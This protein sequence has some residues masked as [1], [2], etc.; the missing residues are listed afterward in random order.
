MLDL[1]LPVVFAIFIWWFSTGVVILLNRMSQ[2]GVRLGQVLSS[3]LGLAALAGLTHTAWQTTEA[4]AYCAFTCALLVWG[5][6]EL[7]FLTGWITGP[8]KTRL[9]EGL[10]ER[11][12]F[13][14]AVRAILW[15]EIGIIAVGLLIVAITWNAP[16][17]VG[18]QT[19]LVLW[20]MRTSAKLNLFLGV[21]NLSEAFLP[22][23]LAYLESFFRRRPMNLLFPVSVI[24]PSIVLA[25]MVNKG[26]DPHTT[27]T[28][29]IGLTLVGTMLALAILEHW[30]LVLPLDTTA[31]WRWAIREAQNRREREAP[32]D[33]LI[34]PHHGLCPIPLETD[35]KLLRAR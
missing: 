13:V 3:L 12:R 4:G 24:V 1:I 33:S 9:P 5:W 18:A 28:A 17:Q 31:L 6:H 22:A 21:R 8:R 14:E 20:A 32:E 15:H 34:R 26:L 7:S 29:V 10:A 23:H 16:N 25:M 11:E 35:E 19:F 30:L 2:R 27:P